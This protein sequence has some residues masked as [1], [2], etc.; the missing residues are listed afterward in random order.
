MARAM[1]GTRPDFIKTYLLIPTSTIV[2]ATIH[3]SIFGRDWIPRFCRHCEESPLCGLRVSTHIENAADFPQ[4]LD[5]RRGR[6]KP[7]AGF[8]YGSESNSPRR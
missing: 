8:R 4:C 6:D 1:L 3:I 5:R 7:Y 2:G